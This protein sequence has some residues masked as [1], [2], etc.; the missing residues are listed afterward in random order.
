LAELVVVAERV[1]LV[2]Q[3][4]MDPLVAAEEVEEVVP[5]HLETVV[6]VVLV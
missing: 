5:Q 6:L 4:E 1:S 3:V 2:V